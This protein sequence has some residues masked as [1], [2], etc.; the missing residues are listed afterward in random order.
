[1][2]GWID[3]F[4]ISGLLGYMHITYV[5]DTCVYL[6][7]CIYIYIHV[8][9]YIYIHVYIY[10]YMCIYI[11]TSYI[12]M[13]MY[14][15]YVLYKLA[16]KRY[17]I[18]WCFGLFSELL[19]GRVGIVGLYRLCIWSFF[20]CF[21]RGSYRWPFRA[22]GPLVFRDS[23]FWDLGLKLVSKEVWSFGV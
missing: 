4:L 12:S 18:T 22:E 11:Y 3:R 17:V 1:M 7:V 5:L 8:Y 14:L 13:Y 19:G 10:T 6:C 23:R 15:T 2:D 21:D 9:I 20:G 16:P